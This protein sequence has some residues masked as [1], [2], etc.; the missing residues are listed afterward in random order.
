MIKSKKL[1]RKLM[2]LFWMSVIGVIGM[3]AFYVDRRIPDQLSMVVNE[4]EEFDFA[5]PFEVT[6]LSESEEVMLG[7]ES[8]IPANEIRLKAEE[9]LSL[10]V[11][12]KGTYQLGMKLFGKVQLKEI[13]LEVEE[14][15]YAVPCGMPVGIYM[16]SNGIM[17]IGTGQIRDENGEEKEPAYGIL[18][19]GDYIEAINGQPLHDKEALITSLNRIGE[20]EALLRIRRS[21]DC[22]EVAV[23]PVKAEDGTYKLGAWVR[24]DT[25]GIGTMTYV[26]KNGQFGALGHGISDSDTG[27]IVEMKD[28]NLYETEILGI[29]KGSVG[30]PGVMAG[31]IYYGPGTV[32]GEVDQN[33]EN[34]IFGIIGE[35]ME[36][37][38]DYPAMEVG[39]RQD[40]KKG[41]AY[42]RSSVSGQMCDYTIEIQ[43]ADLN[44]VQ[45]NKSLVIKVTDPELLR[46]TGGIVQGMSGSPIIQDG[47][48]VGAVT[49]V[50]INDPTRGYG[51]FIEDMMEH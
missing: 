48:L 6:L 35:K 39:Y 44:P 8:N 32:L 24:D 41:T 9:P 51:I 50:F 33:T 21:G 31:V 14:T 18:Q 1:R 45:E 11:K 37:L 7:N 2:M 34:G 40:V 29:E 36:Y 42:I 38:L 19:T 20:S 3:T 43:K 4:P 46:L 30:N 23:N 17:V 16:K 47:K 12:H 15:R 27:R 10:L 49:H 22:M 26:G 28:G 13:R 5:L 25:Q